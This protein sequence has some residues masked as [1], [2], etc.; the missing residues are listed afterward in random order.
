ML[1]ITEH[2]WENISSNKMIDLKGVTSF[3]IYNNGGSAFV[4]CGQTILPNESYVFLSDGTVSNFRQTLVF[5]N[6]TGKEKQAVLELRKI[7][8]YSDKIGQNTANK[9]NISGLSD[10]E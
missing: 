2:S 6:N 4:I 3:R 7:I 10:E 1:L 5:L 9:N 8:G